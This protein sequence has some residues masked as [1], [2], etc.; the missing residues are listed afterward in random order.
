M[1][2]RSPGTGRALSWNMP[3]ANPSCACSFRPQHQTVPSP[4]N[5][6]ANVPPTMTLAT[7]DAPG[8]CFGGCQGSRGRVYPQHHTDRVSVVAHPTVAPGSILATGGRCHFSSF[9]LSSPPQHQ[10]AAAASRA[11]IRLPAYASWRTGPENV[12]AG[13]ALDG[14]PGFGAHVTLPSAWRVHVSHLSA[15][16]PSMSSFDIGALTG[17]TVAR[18]KGL[19]CES[20][21][22]GPSQHQVLSRASLTH[23]APENRKGGIGVCGSPASRATDP[24]G[25]AL[26]GGRVSPVVNDP[27]PH[28]QPLAITASSA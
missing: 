3:R 6:H 10:S 14:V 5:A 21:R 9:R 13:S 27:L 15:T 16:R 23:L 17:R 28:R 19:A 2:S 25:T 18:R 12:T 26:G 20:K 22:G 11:Q 1:M 24:A 8:T 7:S 4:C